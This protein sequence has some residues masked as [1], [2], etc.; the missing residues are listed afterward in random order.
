MGRPGNPSNDNQ[1]VPVHDI[2]SAEWVSAALG[3]MMVL[4]AVAYLVYS[5]VG[6]TG[7]P[8]EI[9]ITVLAIEAQK[10]GYLV[11]TRVSNGGTSTAAQ[12]SIEGTLK[13]KTGEEQRSEVTLDYV[14]AGSETNAGLFFTQD[15]RQGELQVRPVSYQDP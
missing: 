14:A 1:P 10:T 12:L 2:P 4:S 7:S 15:P 11:R 9:T 3:L 8:P 5:S 13:T 6:R